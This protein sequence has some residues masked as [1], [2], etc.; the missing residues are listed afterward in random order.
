MIGSIKEDLLQRELS[1]GERQSINI[2]N[3][4]LSGKTEL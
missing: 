3:S 1:D 4:P 2:P